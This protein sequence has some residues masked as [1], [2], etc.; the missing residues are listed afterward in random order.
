MLLRIKEEQRIL[1]EQRFQEEQRK[2][3]MTEKTEK[4][5]KLKEELIKKIKLDEENRSVIENQIAKIEREEKKILKYFRDDNED[6]CE[7][8]INNKNQKSSPRKNNFS[9]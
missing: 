9:D 8:I 1:E 2:T 5:N 4:K 7:I 3:K 6:I